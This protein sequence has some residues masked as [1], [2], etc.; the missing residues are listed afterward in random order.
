MTACAAEGTLKKHE[1]STSITEVDGE[2]IIES[3]SA[4]GHTTPLGERDLWPIMRDLRRAHVQRM[5]QCHSKSC[6]AAKVATGPGAPCIGGLA[7][8]GCRCSR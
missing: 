4:W 3:V 2:S 5:R 6:A 8:S 1:P 7:R